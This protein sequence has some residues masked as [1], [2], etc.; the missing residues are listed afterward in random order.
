MA[1]NPQFTLKVTHSQYSITNMVYFTMSMRV[2]KER[3]IFGSSSLLVSLGITEKLLCCLLNKHHGKHTDKM[4]AGT[5][6]AHRDLCYLSF[7]YGL[8]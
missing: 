6:N 8:K 4:R 2:G 7:L 1:K 3:V 5:Q